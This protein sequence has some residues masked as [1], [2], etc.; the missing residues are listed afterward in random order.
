[1]N[2]L[3]SMNFPNLPGLTLQN[4]Q[5]FP[6]SPAKMALQMNL[7]AN[8]IQQQ[9]GAAEQLLHKNLQLF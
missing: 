7:L 6:P 2:P 5:N 8:Q 9:G 4:L 1:M 3:F